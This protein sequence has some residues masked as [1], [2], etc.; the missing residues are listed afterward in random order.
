MN[1]LQRL[2]N[3]LTDTM[4][5][6]PTIDELIKDIEDSAI[7]VEKITSLVEIK[8]PDPVAKLI[9]VF[10]NKT[11]INNIM[12]QK[13]EYTTVDKDCVGDWNKIAKNLLS[14]KNEIISSVFNNDENLLS[15]VY[16]KHEQ[17]DNIQIIVPNELS[18]QDEDLEPLGELIE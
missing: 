3:V 17:V 18:W 16:I 11:L 8:K 7:S 15:F 1:I 13:L 14:G 5:K 10:K 6:K 9:I 4:P 2:K 12:S